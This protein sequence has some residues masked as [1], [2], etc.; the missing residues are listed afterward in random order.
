MSSHKTYANNTDPLRE[1]KVVPQERE[2]RQM[3]LRQAEDIMSDCDRTVML[4]R[5]ELEHRSRVVLQ[6]MALPEAYL[7]YTM[8]LVN[9]LFWRAQFAAVP[10][11]RRLLLLPRCLNDEAICAGTTDLNGLHC[12]GCSGCII[13]SLSDRAVS[14]GYQVTVAEGTSSALLSLIEDG[15]DAICGVACLD[16]LE[17]SFSRVAELGIPH[18]AVPL[19]RDGCTQTEFDMEELES[20]LFALSAP[21]TIQTPS[22]LPLLRETVHLFDDDEL[23]R[24]VNPYILL[25]ENPNNAAFTT[26]NI[27]VEWLRQGGKRIRP[28][29]TMAAYAVSRYGADILHKEELSNLFPTVVRRVALA[30]EIFHKASL[31]HDDIEDNDFL[32]YGQ[33]TVHAQYGVPTAVNIGDFLVGLGYQLIAGTAEELGMVCTNDLLRYLASIHLELCR[34]Q[35]AELLLPRSD[36]ILPAQVLKIYAQKTAPAFEMSLYAGFRTAKFDIDP[37]LLRQF[38]IYVGEAFQVLND[39]DDWTEER[40]GADAL[41]QR[42]TILRAFAIEAGAVLPEDYTADAI[43]AEYQ[44]TDAILRAER[45]VEKLTQR[46][47]LLLDEI[48]NQPVRDLL[49]FLVRM[50]IGRVEISPADTM[51]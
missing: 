11:Q 18:V 46:A 5:E 8:V 31:V 23:S 38:A 43:Y 14:L 25:T 44:A 51:R 20:F 50:I 6:Q 2:V 29:I 28:F 30:I 24:L 22:Y 9:N 33:A 15:I 32:R 17:K 27:A 13:S 19:L 47:L 1:I 45:L 4:T 41:A 36:T 37:V 12:A 26:E 7:G 16:S 34:G 42:P 21:A 3:I 48:S 35:G 40:Q 49:H 39:L 10:F